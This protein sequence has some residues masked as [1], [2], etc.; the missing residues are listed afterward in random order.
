M[1]FGCGFEMPGMWTDRQT[2][3]HAGRDT[4]LSSR[5]RLISGVFLERLKS[6]LRFSRSSCVF[7]HLASCVKAKQN[8]TGWTDLN[9]E[10]QLRGTF[11]GSRTY[12]MHGCSETRTVSNRLVLNACRYSDAGSR[13]SSVY[14]PRTELYG[15]IVVDTACTFDFRW[16][17]GDKSSG[18]AERDRVRHGIHWSALSRSKSAPS[19][20]RYSYLISLVR[21]SFASEHGMDLFSLRPEKS[22]CVGLCV[23]PRAYLRNDTSNL[24]NFFPW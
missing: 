7:G 18:T 2:H 21:L 16:R 11:F 19:I 14:M 13:S 15:Q 17:P 24:A 9:K 23:V 1:P 20:D 6:V 22:M 4:S 10:T 5:D 3:R 8:W 12:W